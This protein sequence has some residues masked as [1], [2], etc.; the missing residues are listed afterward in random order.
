MILCSSPPLPPPPKSQVKP[1]SLLPSLPPLPSP[2]PPPPPKRFV[3]GAGGAAVE[4]THCSHLS[5]K[6]YKYGITNWYAGYGNIA[7]KGHPPKKSRSRPPC[8][9]IK[10]LPLHH[11]FDIY[12]DRRPPLSLCLSLPRAR[13]RARSL[14][15]YTHTH[16]HIHTRIQGV[17]VEHTVA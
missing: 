5:T 4:I 12:L 17:C 9:P 11:S 10:A 3:C 8:T 16:T 15:R 2:P 7:D 14:S 13:A 6:L 1:L